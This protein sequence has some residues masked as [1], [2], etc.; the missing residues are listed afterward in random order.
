MPLT[1]PRPPGPAQDHQPERGQR[2]RGVQG[3]AARGGQPVLGHPRAL[4]GDR[5][6][7]G[8]CRHRGDP[9]RADAAS[10]ATGPAPS[11]GGTSSCRS[12]PRGWWW[13]TTSTT[14]AGKA[15]SGARCRPTSTGRSGC[16]GVVTDGSVRDLDEV[17][18]L[19]FQFCG[20]P[21]LGLPRHTSTW[22]TSGCPVKVGGVW[23]KPGDLIHADQHGVVTVPA[24]IADRHPR[25]HR[26]RGGQG[27]P[28]HR[29]CASRRT[30]RWQRL[31]ALYGE[32]RPGT[33]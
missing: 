25:G 17:R 19:G 30:S 33:Y 13:S 18:A 5:P 6:H 2:H 12:R 26:R 11:A 7:R 8:L 16:V 9:R 4:P 20:R 14:P 3:A 22:S 10:R 27:A 31:R 15:P 32:I 21:R 28:H 23:I 24:E 1:E 29:R